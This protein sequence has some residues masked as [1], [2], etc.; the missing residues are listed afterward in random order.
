M[1][2]KSELELQIQA[3]RDEGNTRGVR[4]LRREL[5]RYSDL[6]R[7]GVVMDPSIEVELPSKPEEIPALP[8]DIVVET[9]KVIEGA[10]IPTDTERQ[11]LKDVGLVFATVDTRTFGE[12]YEKSPEKFG[13][14][15][16]F[17]K[18][19]SLGLPHSIE[20]AYDPKNPYLPNSNNLAQED[21]IDLISRYSREQIEPAAPQAKAVMFTASGYA[22]LDLMQ[23]ATQGSKLFTDFYAGA[24]DTFRSFGRHYVANV[25]RLAEDLRLFADG[26]DP[27]STNHPG[28]HA[29]P[30]VV[31]TNPPKAA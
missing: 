19:N 13:F 14:V 29:V 20:V 4:A 24:L 8:S 31:F 1:S 27:Q 21:Q 9:L 5:K 11:A 2:V 17:L 16:S 3:A 22:Q 25:G 28:V 18:Q 15:D 12:V 10:R 26:R 7:E 23:Q 30:V 6:V